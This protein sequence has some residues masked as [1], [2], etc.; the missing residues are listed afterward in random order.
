MSG[1]LQL[2]DPEC[3]FVVFMVR[4]LSLCLSLFVC[5]C[6]CVCVF[7]FVR[8]Q[9]KPCSC[10]EVRRRRRWNQRGWRKLERPQS[11]PAGA[12]TGPSQQ[13]QGQE[14]EPTA[15]AAAGAQET[16]PIWSQSLDT[17]WDSP[18]APT[19]NQQRQWQQEPTAAELLADPEA[20]A[21]YE[22]KARRGSC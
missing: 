1:D 20:F 8:V 21:D 2:H 22:A 7:I 16:D 19:K 4:S 15:A 18:A 6:V 14:Q 9:G 17:M 5:V 10:K 3:D 13:A 12:A 11:A